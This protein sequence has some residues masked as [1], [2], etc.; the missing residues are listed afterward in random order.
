MV[1]KSVLLVTADVC[2]Q[3]VGLI[4][5]V[6][7]NAMVGQIELQSKDWQPDLFILLHHSVIRWT[8][9]WTNPWRGQS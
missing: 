1:H 9:P 8:N 5:T 2:G 7:P 3:T 4:A 6:W